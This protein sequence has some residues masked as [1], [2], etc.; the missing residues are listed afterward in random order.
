M[1]TFKAFVATNQRRSDGTYNVKIRCTLKRKSRWIA[2]NVFVTDDDLTRGKKFKNPYIIAKCDAL[3]K[4]LR[5]VVSDLSPFTV[6]EMDVDDVVA[7]IKKKKQSESFKLDFFQFGRDYAA[8]QPVGSGKITVTALNAFSRFMGVEECDI[9]DITAAHVRAFAEYLDAEPKTSPRR[10]KGAQTSIPKKKGGASFKYISVLRAVFKKARD[11]YNDEDSGQILIPRAP[12]ERVKVREGTHVGQPNLG[13]DIMQRIISANTDKPHWR[14]ALDV[15]ILSFGTM[16]ANVADLYRAEPLVDGVW[17]YERTK[18]ANHRR[19][20]A[21]MRITIPRQL[22]SYVGRL[23][24]VT[25]ARWL[26]LYLAGRDA[27]AVTQKVNRSLKA[28]AESEG[29]EPFTMYAARHSWASIARSSAV[30]IEKVTVDDCLNHVN[31]A[32]ADI[33]IDKDFSVFD[34]A[35]SKVLALFTFPS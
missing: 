30:G 13:P 8:T 28:W 10:K 2:T 22:D 1:I 7:Y 16:G 12:F 3:V 26:R 17:T 29:I 25:G 35:N 14:F 19:D 5:D 20:R 32:V 11:R 6:D 27:S 21:R 18:T 34:A 15:F 33:Y 24:D 9:N 23:R 4:D 31:L